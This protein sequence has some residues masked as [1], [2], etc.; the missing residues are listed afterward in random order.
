MQKRE[1]LKPFVEKAGY[2]SL[3]VYRMKKGVA[4]VW[5]FATNLA[6]KEFIEL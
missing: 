2:E 3:A 4:T 5:T 6:P 1:F